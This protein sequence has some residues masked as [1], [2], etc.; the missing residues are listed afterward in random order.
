MQ[1]KKLLGLKVHNLSKIKFLNRVEELVKQ[2]KRSYVVT[3]YSE[4]FVYAKDDKE[5]TNVV[6]SADIS[7]ADGFGVVFGLKYK[8]TLNAITDKS[9]KDQRQDQYEH[10]KNGTVLN[11]DISKNKKKRQ[12]K[13]NENEETMQKNTLLDKYKVLCICLWNA[14]FN[15]MYFN[16]VLKA[17]L[18]G[19]EFIYDVCELAA[20]NHYKVFFLGGFDFGDGNTGELAAK[21]LQKLYPKL[22]I[23]GTYAGSPAIEE[24][25]KIINIINKC[26]PHILF[27]AYGPVKQE[28]WIY[29]NT[30]KLKP[31][32]SFCLG[33]TFDYVAGSKEKVPKFFRDHGME[34]I[35]RPFFSERGD[36]V[37]SFKRL[38][39]SWGG[40]TK[41]LVL[42]VTSKEL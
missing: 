24:E 22:Q 29:R 25:D 3:P 33:G 36:V 32:V 9:I 12:N 34:G 5:F 15:K 31:M 6:N 2:K 4:F 42:L 1:E 16:N 17:K 20:A 19:S 10:S 39:R 41:F 27:I 11:K 30:E 8:D 23:A 28:K 35:M 40:I 18:S 13:R 7:T 37:A 14:L 21:K 38:K 26:K